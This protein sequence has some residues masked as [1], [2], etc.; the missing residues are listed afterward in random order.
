MW[1]NFHPP[2]RGPALR[3][4]HFDAVRQDTGAGDLDLDPVAGREGPDT[5]RSSGQQ[6]VARL[7]RHH[8]RHEDQELENREL[9]IGRPAALALLAAHAGDDLERV[10]VGLDGDGGTQGAEG[11]ERLG[12]GEGLVA[13]LQ[14]AGGD[15]AGAGDAQDGRGGLLVRRLREGA[16]YND[17]DLALE[18][19]A[20]A[21]LGQN[22]RS[23]RSDDRRRGF[24]E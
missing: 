6:D 20:L 19:D 10:E 12:A 4:T 5:R 16:A 17:G 8:A 23:R 3:A 24:Q 2:T 15:V 18:V 21:L 14:I 9:H 1:A 13:A 22:D 7:E 11:V